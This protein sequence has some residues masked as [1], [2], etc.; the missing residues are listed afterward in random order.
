MITLLTEGNGIRPTARIVGIHRDTVLSILKF[1]GQRSE[2]LLKRKLIDVTAEH[3]EVD[4]IW[5][6]VKKK[7]RK[8]LDPEINM[9]WYGDYYTFLGMES[10]T[11]LMFL[12]LVGKRTEIVRTTINSMSMSF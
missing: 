9:G 6:F 12:P 1:A 4:E 2:E 7:E 11:K 8:Y 10:K 5:T 3:I